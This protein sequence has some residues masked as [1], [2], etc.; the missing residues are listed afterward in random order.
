MRLLLIIPAFN[1]AKNITSVLREV[2]QLQILQD[3]VV[4]DDGSSDETAKLAQA[5]GV[6]VLKLP[7]NLGYG[8][9]LQTG[10]SYA[11]SKDYEACVLM[12][13]D[14]QHN[15]HDI[16][17]LLEPVLSGEADLSLGSRFLKENRVA[18]PFGRRWGIFIFGKLLSFF[19]RQ[20]ITDPTSGLQVVHRRLFKCFLQDNYPHDYPDSDTLLKLHYASYS[21][22]EVP[23]SIRPR[24]QGISMH[25]GLSAL[26][27]LYKMFFS[28]FIVFSQRKNLK[29]G[30]PKCTSALESSSSH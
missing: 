6:R 11:L 18:M 10:F 24:T 7:I 14:G 19:T 1:E 3:I 28:I 29:S 13:G 27:Y 5:E 8:A 9:A 2:K 25:S 21:I 17:S 16:P 22:R 26:Y 20:K 4:V 23:V 30:G 12:D 15:P